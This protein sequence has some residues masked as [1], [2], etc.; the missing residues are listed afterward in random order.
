MQPT[1]VLQG[2]KYRKLR[3]TTKDV[4]KGFYK[5]N[6][7]GSM[8]TH[9]SYGTYKIDYTKVRTYVCPDL[10][11][12]KLTPFVSKTISPVHD[13]FPGDKLGPRNPTTYLAR[14]KSENGL[15]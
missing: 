7:T 14:W 6:R 3:L 8:G 12:F 1:R 10:T 11:G 5:G 15:D 4:N 2:L 13:Q 9:T